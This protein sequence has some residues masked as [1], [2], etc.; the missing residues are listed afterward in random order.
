MSLLII[1]L[2]IEVKTIAAFEDLLLYIGAHN[3]FIVR[4][5]LV[6]GTLR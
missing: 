5:A 6:A 2:S 1:L 3:W 4:Q